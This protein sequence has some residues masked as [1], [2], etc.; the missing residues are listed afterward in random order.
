MGDEARLHNENTGTYI[1]QDHTLDVV[2][3]TYVTEYITHTC[4]GFSCE[5]KMENRRRRACRVMVWS[6][7]FEI[8]II[9]DKKKSPVGQHIGEEDQVTFV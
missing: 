5:E 4:S 9:F 6:D 8:Q 1:E 7:E 2:R 3:C